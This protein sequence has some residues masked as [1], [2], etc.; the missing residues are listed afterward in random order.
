MKYK[1]GDQ[2]RLLNQIG[3]G[4]VTKIINSTTVSVLMEDG[5]E[6]PFIESDIFKVVEPTSYAEKMFLKGKEF[7]EPNLEKSKNADKSANKNENSKYIDTSFSEQNY[8]KTPESE[9][10]VFERLSPLHKGFVKDNPQTEGVY[11][12]FVPT[13]QQ[14]FIK[15]SID[16]F[17]INYSPYPFVYN[18]VLDC[19][20]IYFGMD[21]DTIPA[22]HKIQIQN[23]ER[24]EI[25]E[26]NQGIIQG[27]FHVEESDFLAHPIH[28]TFKVPSIKFSQPEHYIFTP[29]LREKSL[30]SKIGEVLHS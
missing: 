14:W 20:G 24:D 30:L 17:L 2:V 18:F 19:K 10:T 22:G 11:L 27:F 25:N 29:F 28:K 8:E 23:I 15:D 5:F 26:W 3:Q 4:K 7:V 16:I 21:Y 9:K 6:L 12:A 13:D 1:I